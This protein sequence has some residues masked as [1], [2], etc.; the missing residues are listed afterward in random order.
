MKWKILLTL[1]ALSLP[2]NLIANGDDD[3]DDD[4]G[5]GGGQTAQILPINE[6]HGL[7]TDDD[8]LFL[9]NGQTE[10]A[11][12]V[13]TDDGNGLSGRQGYARLS[14]QTASNL[15][16][17]PHS[18]GNTYIIA[19]SSGEIRASL[20]GSNFTIFIATVD[21]NIDTVATN[22]GDRFYFANRTDGLKYSTG[23]V[24]IVSSTTMKVNQLVTHKGRL[25]AVGRIDDPRTIYGSAYLNGDDW[26]LK[27]DPVDTDPVRIQV[28]GY[29]DEA[30]TVL[31]ASFKD[32]LIWGK[33]S[34]FGEIN[35]SRRSNFGSRAYSENIGISSAESVK[36]CDGKLRWVDNKKRVWEFDGATYKEI[37]DDINELM[38]TT[39]Q[40]GSNTKSWDQS[41]ASD[42]GA[43]SFQGQLSTT[44][45]P[46]DIV[47]ISLSR[48]DDNFEDNDLTQNPAWNNPSGFTS[49]DG[50]VRAVCNGGAA[51]WKE[52]NLS[53]STWVFSFVDTLFTQIPDDSGSLPQ[54]DFM[55]N[56]ATTDRNYIV[57]QSGTGGQNEITVG[58]FTTTL[59]TLATVISST[60]VSGIYANGNSN[61]AVSRD[62]RGMFFLYRVSNSGIYTSLGNAI[63]TFVTTSD[64]FQWNKGGGDLC[65]HTAISSITTITEGITNSTFTSQTFAIG[66]AITGW[67]A[68]TAN[69][70]LNG[71]SIRYSIYSD[72]DTTLS[73]TNR[74]TFIGSQTI[75]SGQIPSITTAAYVTVVSSFSRTFSTNTPT[76]NDFQVTWQD[77]S[78]L[79]LIGQYVNNRYWLGVS[80]SSP[81]N[82]RVLVYDR[83]NDWH[84]YTIPM[85]SGVFYKGNFYFGNNG[86][87]FQAES[88]YTDNGS[89]IPS[90][91]K[92]KNFTLG[93]LNYRKTFD[94]FYVTTTNNDNTLQTQYYV[95]G[96]NTAYNFANYTMN[97]ESGL[98]DFLLPFP[99]NQLNTGKTISFKWTVNGSSRWTILN[100]NLYYTSDTI[101]SD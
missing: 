71:G 42:W 17:F 92:T 50:Y 21:P 80:I 32:K 85:N 24:A 97:G 34:S 60:V 11:E 6:F 23:S 88:G 3:D 68:F 58:L 48:P 49:T 9:K 13:V 84:K 100:G 19:Q 29:L 1:L 31:F 33:T 4:N 53:V 25:F 90:F 86:G 93:V 18:N 38:N 83:N 46:G 51:L 44:S 14:T 67:G 62:A 8:P 72:S 87:I 15:W 73:I 95:D 30:V 69:S 27:V 55:A 81:V 101:A 39:S 2:Q 94:D 20:G 98:Q 63:S 37:S 35:G 41:S 70:Q 82:N 99:F 74:T 36:D 61:V 64:R 79:K 78:T 10:D 28:Q 65:V 77:T 54:I 22:L 43:G 26:T 76:L 96:V 5:G 52:S 45:S 7:N 66:P 59:S 89:A 40:S 16:T 91:Y 57:A 47:M 12:N 56:N 75:T